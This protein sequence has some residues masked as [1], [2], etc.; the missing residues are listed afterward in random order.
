MDASAVNAFRQ[1][2][3][4]LTGAQV[5]DS[6]GTVVGVVVGRVLAGNDVDLLVRR[7]RLFHRSVYRR[8]EGD[9]ITISGR[10]FVYDPDA[11]RSHVMSAIVQLA[12][13]PA[14][15]SHGDAA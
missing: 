12:M 8:L 3:A 1:P 15:V 2:L 13:L 10:R 11:I 7:R 9:A 6:A 5:V 4:R 14:Q